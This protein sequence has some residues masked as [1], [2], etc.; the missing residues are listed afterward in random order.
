[1]P[2]TQQIIDALTEID[3]CPIPPGYRS[4]AKAAAAEIEKLRAEQL[5]LAQRIHNQRVALRRNWE[6]IESRASHR[7]AW[8][9][10]PLLASM[11]RR[12]RS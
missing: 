3:Y 6:I 10:S 5:K 1:M 11:L 4:I 2:T 9:R 12:P 8:V 7:R